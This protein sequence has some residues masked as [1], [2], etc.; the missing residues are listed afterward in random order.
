VYRH[1]LANSYCGIGWY[2]TAMGPFYQEWVTASFIGCFYADL[3]CGVSILFHSN[4]WWLVAL[5]LIWG[6]VYRGHILLCWFVLRSQCLNFH[7]NGSVLWG[8]DDSVLFGYLDVLYIDSYCGINV[9]FHSS[10]HF[11][12]IKEIRVG[13]LLA[14][15]YLSFSQLALR[16]WLFVSQQWHVRLV[17]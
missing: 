8:I 5:D 12:W 15:L 3:Y 11:R 14:D 10:R 13:N 17:T 6:A 9:L 1:K 4:V 7:S 2:Y 16:G